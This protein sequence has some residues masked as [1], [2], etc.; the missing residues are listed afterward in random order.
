M[1]G[2]GAV[3]GPKKVFRAAKLRGK[4]FGPSRGSGDMLPS[5]IFKIK[6]PM[7]AKSSFPEIQL[8]K[9]R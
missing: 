5:K 8:G 7:L 1:P 3:S 4:F 6:G 9:T 2:G